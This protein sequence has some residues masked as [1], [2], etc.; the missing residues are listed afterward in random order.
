MEKLTIGIASYKAPQKLKVTIDSLLATTSEFETLL[1]VHNPSPGDEET[2]DLIKDYADKDP[3]ITYV[4]MAN[5]EGYVGAVN[6]LLTAANTP[7]IAY[8]DNDV[9]FKTKD[10]DVKFRDVLKHEEVGQVFPGK[11]HHG[12]FSGQYDE[13]LW[14]AGYCWMTRRDVISKLCLADVKHNRSNDP[15]RLDTSLGH[16][17]EV[18]L[19]IRLR[20]TG[21]RIGTAPSVEVL[22]HETATHSPESEQRIHD[23]V[24]RWMNKWNGYFCGDIL[25]Y[26]MTAYDPCALRYTDWHPC[27]LYLERYTL[28]YYPN[29]NKSPRSVNFPSVGTMDA[30]EV[31]KPKGPYAGRAI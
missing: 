19:M 1:V 21:Y 13:C 9:E 23:G 22:H 24:V 7:L 18:D 11:G 27:A 26:S 28:H 17:E 29:W 6:Y 8:C 25:Q 5:N 14:N 31:I 4:I 10:W 15:G 16:H 30:V 20:L 2:R 3:R 12:F